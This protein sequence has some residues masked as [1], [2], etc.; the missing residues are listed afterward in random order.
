MDFD[1]TDEERMIQKT[2]RDFAARE[3]APRVREFDREQCYD[4]EIFRKMGKLGFTGGVLPQKYGGSELSYVGLALMIEELAHACVFTAILA[5]FASCSGGQG[6]LKY[7]TEEQKL[8][9]LAAL[10][11]GEKP[12]ATGITE[13]HSGTDIVRVME[14]SVKKEGD[15]YVVNGT[16]AWITNLEHAQWFIT[17]AQMDKSRGHKGICAFIIEKN[18]P[19]VTVK[20]YTNLMGS[21]YSKTGDLIFEDVHVPKENLVG[22]EFEGYKVLMSGTEI[23]RLACAARSLGQTRACLE[24][25]INYAKQRVVFGRPISEFQ[26]IKAKIADMVV[27]LEAGRFLTYHLAW[28]KD[29]GIEGVQRE[30]SIA[31]FYTS[32]T[33]MKASTEAVQIHGA[34]GIHDEYNVGRY[35]SHAKV[36]QIY[37]GTQ[38]IHK[39]IIGDH[40][41]GFRRR[42]KGDE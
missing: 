31:K 28:M 39:I 16:K 25:S 26:L 30:A 2:A 19:G 36:T 6:T 24:E 10:C 32:D 34:Y 9:Y 27:G 38:E 8:K 40:A 14:T 1:F 20:P 3:V 37:D 23:G 42:Y 7:G 41:L 17:F 12:C 11:R 29:K 18:W 22:N 13:P 15:H 33:F 21:R 4:I 5:G 35:F